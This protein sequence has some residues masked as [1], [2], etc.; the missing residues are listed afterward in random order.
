MTKE[1]EK[2]GKKRKE[3]ERAREREKAKEGEPRWLGFA[4][5]SNAF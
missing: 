5:Y 1:E 3:G 4:F 2:G